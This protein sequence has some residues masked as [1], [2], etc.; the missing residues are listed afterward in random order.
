MASLK[1]SATIPEFQNAVDEYI[2]LMASALTRS[3][4]VFPS[5][6]YDLESASA[7]VI[8]R[9]QK[10]TD[11]N[12]GNTLAMLVDVNAALSRFSSRLSLEPL[13]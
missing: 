5:F 12:A 13:L 3:Q 7:I 6:T 10:T 9:I 2:A 4:K 1:P 8:S 11:A